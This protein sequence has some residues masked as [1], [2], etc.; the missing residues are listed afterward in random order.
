VT[1]LSSA[2]FAVRTIKD[3]KAHNTLRMVCLSYIH[4][5]MIYDII[6]WNNSPHS[7]NIF[8]IQKHMIRIIMNANVRDSCRELLSFFVKI[9]I[10][11]FSEEIHSIN[12][13]Y[14]TN[15]HL[16]TSSLAVYQSG[17]YYF[18]IIVNHII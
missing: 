4:S 14:S 2:C 16:P 17:A 12:T 5:V 6:S 8:K 3:L 11:K 18:G 9:K 7:V 10:N 13:R 1:K 15:L